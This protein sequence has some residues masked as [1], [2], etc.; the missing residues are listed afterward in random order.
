MFK[1]RREGTA[2]ASREQVVRE[3]KRLKYVPGGRA[4]V[5]RGSAGVGGGRAA[6]GVMT[7]AAAPAAATAQIDACA[8]CETFAPG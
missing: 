3:Q 4:G 8:L 7:G 1:L 5:G 2:A 6:R